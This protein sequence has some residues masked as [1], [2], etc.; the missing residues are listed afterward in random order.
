MKRITA[1]QKEMARREKI[2]QDFVKKFGVE[3]GSMKSIISRAETVE[4][5]TDVEEDFIGDSFVC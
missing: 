3:F 1:Y 2:E 4:A 5:D